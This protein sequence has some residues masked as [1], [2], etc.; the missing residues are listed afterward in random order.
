MSVWNVLI[1]SG[2]AAAALIAWGDRRFIG[3]L[4]LIVVT[5]LASV[6]YWDV[7]GPYAEAVGFLFDAFLVA[8]L[9]LRGQYRWEMRLALL[10]LI[11]AFIN[12]AYLAH[13]LVGAGLIPHD[14][15]GAALELVNILAIFTIGFTAAF[16]RAGYT[17]GRAFDRWVHIFG[18]V[19][20]VPERRPSRE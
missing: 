12:M 3:W 4:A 18:V 20:H 15:H 2:A 1:L 11:S 17:D 19:R 5:Y 9:C 8:A 16:G 7:K 10:Y 6:A 13:N 14:A